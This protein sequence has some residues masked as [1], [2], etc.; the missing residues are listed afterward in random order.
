[1]TDR[2]KDTVYLGCV[3]IVGGSVYQTYRPFKKRNMK[4][5]LDFIYQK[6]I[7]E[8]LTKKSLP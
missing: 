8:Y 7:I 5:K 6:Y 4:E 1:M 3:K 2:E